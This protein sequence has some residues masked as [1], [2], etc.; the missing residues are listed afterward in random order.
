MSK[1]GRFAAAA[2]VSLFLIGL[3]SITVFHAD[4]EKNESCNAGTD[5]SVFANM[6]QDLDAEIT[7]M[8]IAEMETSQYG[9]G[10]SY[11]QA[12]HTNS[13]SYPEIKQFSISLTNIAAVPVYGTVSANFGKISKHRISF[14]SGASNQVT[15]NVPDGF[16]AVKFDTITFKF[17]DANARLIDE[18]KTMVSYNEDTKQIEVFDYSIGN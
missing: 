5:A 17:Y 6:M 18:F 7:S 13:I 12:E 8:D 16:D 2:A 1:K 4:I 11:I 15:Y 3:C 10:C 14:E 9:A